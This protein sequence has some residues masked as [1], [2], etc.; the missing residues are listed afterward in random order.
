MLSII[1][2][3]DM[4]A[5][6]NKKDNDNCIVSLFKLFDFYKNLPDNLRE[7]TLTGATVSLVLMVL[8]TLL[9]ITKTYE[10]RH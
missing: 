10:F 6:I 5:Q 8:M 4:K 7:P 9:V 3:K 1:K 2:Y